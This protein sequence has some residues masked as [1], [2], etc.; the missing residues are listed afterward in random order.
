MFWGISEARDL[1]DEYLSGLKLKKPI[2]EKLDILFYGLGDPGHL[3]KTI[4][5]INQNNAQNIQFNF[6][7]IEGC[8]ELLARD[9]L[10][11]A[12]PFEDDQV[13]SINGRAHLYMDL[14]GNTLIHPS[15]AMFLNA[16][17][18]IFIKM[19]TDED[20]ATRMM[21][22]FDMSHL[23]YRERDQLEMAFTFW[24]NRAEHIYDIK[25]YWNDQNRL[26]LK[27]RYDHR[28]GAF[29]WDLQMKLRNNGVK[30]ICSQE[31]KHWRETGIAFTFPEY[32][33][34]MP[35]KTFAMDLRRNGKQWFHRGYVGDMTVGPYISFGLEC[36]DE[37][38]LKSNF[39]TNQC[40]STDITE[41][42][43]YE[44]IWEL[45]HGQKYDSSMD[46]KTF[47]QYGAVKLSVA[48]SPS[49]GRVFDDISVN[50]QKYDMPLKN[51]PSNV[52]IYFLPIEDVL[53]ITKKHQFHQKFDIA[54]VAHNYVSFLKND[55]VQL[56]NDC[57]ILLLETRKYSV[58]K[59]SEINEAIQGMKKVCTEMKLKPIT[60]FSLNIIPSILKY[61]SIQ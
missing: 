33:H 45:Q 21:P 23:K 53:D 15:S 34:T 7:V 11:M 35:N 49:A 17:S 13:L 2:N 61:K 40:R 22:I 6:Y 20:F 37:A 16:K 31:Y 18:E 14:Y 42:N 43:I 24:K 1:Y 50:L 3:L 19:I 59:Q 27:E 4:A 28:E 48:E 60:N 56:L 36:A 10:L 26:Q 54:F 9:L 38:M 32:E 44:M 29:D 47:R 39:G 51:L 30:Q 5:K 58:M 57:S 8:V 12:L 41:R 46:N 52:K 55:F 25:K